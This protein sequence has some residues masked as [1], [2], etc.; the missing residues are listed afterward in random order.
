[1]SHLPDPSG[2][3]G[4]RAEV[5]A[6]F[7]NPVVSGASTTLYDLLRNQE[8]L[9]STLSQ[10]DQPV[11][12][13]LAVGSFLGLMS[14]VY[15]PETFTRE[16]WA[17]M[18]FAPFES[19]DF[20]KPVNAGD[21]WNWTWPEGTDYWFL[22]RISSIEAVGQT[23]TV[24]ATNQENGFAWPRISENGSYEPSRGERIPLI[25]GDA[26]RFPVPILAAP[27]STTLV[28]PIDDLQTSSVVISSPLDGLPQAGT[29][30]IGG[31]AITYTGLSP[32]TGELTGVTRGPQG[33]TRE[34]A[35]SFH[36]GGER[37]FA[38][39][40]TVLCL[41][42]EGTSAVSA[43]YVRTNQ[44]NHPVMIPSSFYALGRLKSDDPDGV[45]VPIQVAQIDSADF[46]EMILYYQRSA[47]TRQVKYSTAADVELTRTAF[48]PS[49]TVTGVWYATLACGRRLL[50]DPR[51]GATTSEDTTLNTLTRFPYYPFPVLKNTLPLDG[52]FDLY[53]ELINLNATWNDEQG[54]NTVFSIGFDQWEMQATLDGDSSDLYQGT[55]ISAPTNWSAQTISKPGPSVADFSVPK[56]ITGWY[57]SL[58]PDNANISGIS[59]DWLYTVEF[60]YTLTVDAVED[61]TD[62]KF[63]LAWADGSKNFYDQGTTAGRVIDEVTAR[64]AGNYTF[65]WTVEA[66][67]GTQVSALDEVAFVVF[68]GPG[69]GSGAP[70]FTI[71]LDDGSTRN[72]VTGTIVHSASSSTTVVTDS[73]SHDNLEPDDGE[74]F[75]WG[76][77]TPLGM[78]HQL[79][80]GSAA[81]NTFDYST[82]TQ[83]LTLPG[84]KNIERSTTQVWGDPAFVRP[85]RVTFDTS[86]DFQ[87]MVDDGK[88]DSSTVGYSARL[89]LSFTVPYTASDQF[90]F[91]WG[92]YPQGETEGGSIIT[93]FPHARS[94]LERGPLTTETATYKT[95]P[96]YS[97]RFFP[98]E[99]FRDSPMA[100]WDKYDWKA[101]VEISN[102]YTTYGTHNNMGFLG[103]IAGT[104]ATGFEPHSGWVWNLTGA[105]T[106]NVEWEFD[107]VSVIP[108]AQR[109]TSPELTTAAIV[110]NPGAF[111]LEFFA[112]ARGPLASKGEADSPAPQYPETPRPERFK[113][114]QAF[115]A[116]YGETTAVANP[117]DILKRW[118]ERSDSATNPGTSLELFEA[119]YSDL[120]ASKNL[121]DNYNTLFRGVSAPYVMGFDARNLGSDWESVLARIAWEARTNIVRVSESKTASYNTDVGMPFRFLSAGTAPGYSF[122]DSVAQ[123]AADDVL[124]FDFV[125]KRATEVANSTV[126]FYD[127]DDSRLGDANN[128]NRYRRTVDRPL[129]GRP[130]QTLDLATAPS[131]ASFDIPNAL[132]STNLS[133]EITL[134]LTDHGAV[135]GEVLTLSGASD[136]GS[137]STTITEEVLEESGG[138]VVTEIIDDD[139]L[140][141][142]VSVAANET[143][144]S[145]GGVGLDVKFYRSPLVGSVGLAPLSMPFPYSVVKQDAATTAFWLDFSGSAQAAPINAIRFQIGRRKLFAAPV[146]QNS[147]FTGE[148][149]FRGFQSYDTWGTDGV[150]GSPTIKITDLGL[151]DPTQPGDP[152]ENSG[153]L[154]DMVF[155]LDSPPDPDPSGTWAAFKTAWDADDILGVRIQL[156][157]SLGS[158]LSGYELGKVSTLSLYDSEAVASAN[159]VGVHPAAFQ[160]E[161]H[162]TTPGAS[163]SLGAEDWLDYIGGELAKDSR[164]VDVV[165]RSD[166]GWSLELGDVVTCDVP[167]QVL[168]EGVTP[169]SGTV[170]L[171]LIGVSRS[172]E[173]VALRGVVL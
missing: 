72:A 119:D 2:L 63:V 1:M 24:R 140:K 20:A 98:S 10:G 74:S 51:T 133:D 104:S 86:P 62:Q 41:G 81:C 170:Q 39:G 15:L 129:G 171:R 84:G 88:I 97:E 18:P 109:E 31:E 21:T 114:L 3:D 162:R 151:G 93:K 23:I 95:F 139:S 64:E 82:V 173:G 123:L 131:I 80:W 108:P 6:V 65:N 160:L 17:G 132:S 32:G 12:N 141:F 100:T 78:G 150:T 91:L 55:K 35:A 52:S 149:S 136:L 85:F 168:D 58:E 68:A 153:V 54:P 113:D 120:D 49:E 126:A 87:K 106:V 47:V 117:T 115:D 7:V 89:K 92:I 121:N 158:N 142:R 4:I 165:V 125:G 50:W 42:D 103:M 48:G 169:V 56:N 137:G 116:T 144:S 38:P 94:V 155:D 145:G 37:V 69:V 29:L 16:A 75:F 130:I 27:F 26:Y 67:E 60:S 22:G 143:V 134:A 40:R 44:S 36:N 19:P 118:I 138:R 154:V 90:H 34:G 128:P 157:S 166:A 102:D 99:S 122:G 70:N 73:P 57:F 159:R 59:T 77:A 164:L 30:W 28:A 148:L 14:R 110:A 111:E 43:I 5:A 167:A 124:A 25:Y 9:A 146:Q 76:T 45:G 147:T 61:G 163:Y 161:T 152:T 107:T 135:L 53:Q 8:T 112:D 13:I 101:V 46:Q 127:T 96:V 172:E 66:R 71:K 105:I 83:S 79:H 156:D 11:Q 33:G